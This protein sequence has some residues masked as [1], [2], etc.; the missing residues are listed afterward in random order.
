MKTIFVIL[1]ALTALI[2]T[3]AEARKATTHSLANECNISMPCEG[4]FYS[5]AAKRFIGTPFG[6]PVQSYTPSH[7]ASVVSHPSGCPGR[8][9]C[10]CGASV[11]IFGKPVRS[12]YLAANWYKFPRTSPAPGMVAVRRHHVFVLESH[13]EGST[14]MAYDANSGSGKTRIHARSLAGYTVVNPHG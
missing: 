2:A 5:K 14:W 8:A 4:G 11:R 1:A 9:F 3:P 10:G 6:S 7:S 12:L 13:L